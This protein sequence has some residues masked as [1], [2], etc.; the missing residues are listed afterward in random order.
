MTITIMIIISATHC[1]SRETAAAQRRAPPRASQNKHKQITQANKTAQQYAITQSNNKTIQHN[2]SSQGFL[3]GRSTAVPQAVL[4]GGDSAAG[5][6]T[7]RTQQ[8]GTL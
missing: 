3:A 5:P 1:S 2:K 6:M 8:V 4:G 7:R